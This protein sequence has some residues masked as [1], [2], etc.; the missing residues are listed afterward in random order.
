MSAREVERTISRM[1]HE[2]SERLGVEPSGGL[3]R[4]GLAH[5]N[6]LDE[7]ERC[8]TVIDRA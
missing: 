8:L 7:V 2:I 1:A 6:T 4:I 3:V 5:Y